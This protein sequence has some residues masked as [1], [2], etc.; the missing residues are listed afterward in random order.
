MT[1]TFNGGKFRVRGDVVEIFPASRDEHAFRV[2]FFGDEIERIREIE[3]LTGQVLGDVDHLAIFPATHF[4]TNDDHMEVAIA[5][6]QAELEEQLKVFEKE[7]KLL[8]AQRLKQRT[9]YDIEMLRGDGLH[10]WGRK[11]L[12]SYGWPTSR[13][14]TVY[15]IRLLPERF[16]FRVDE[17]HITMSQIRGMYNGDRAR[18]EQLIKYGFRLPSAL[19]NRPLRFEE[20]EER[21]PQIIYIRQLQGLTNYR[22]RQLLPSKSFVQQAYS[23][24]QWKFVQLKDRLM[25]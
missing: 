22:I 19:D 17:S 16:A 25:I 18:K 12:S 23:I 15:F 6:I 3:A 4:V 10:Q 9:E 11:L 21:V 20:F 24:H 1:L 2:E 5:K 13:T 14:T 8:E 7:G